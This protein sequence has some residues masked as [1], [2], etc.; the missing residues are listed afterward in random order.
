M[1]T[2]ILPHKYHGY[3]KMSQKNRTLFVMQWEVS[4]QATTP[5]ANSW[6][7]LHIYDKGAGSVEEKIAGSIEM[8]HHLSRVHSR[9]AT[10]YCVACIK[11]WHPAVVER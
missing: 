7:K 3:K 9:K 6:A 4:Q 5:I 1:I 8:K 10:K 11:T 2:K